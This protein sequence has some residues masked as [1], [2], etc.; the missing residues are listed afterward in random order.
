VLWESDTV[1]EFPTVHPICRETVWRKNMRISFTRW[2]SLFW[3]MYSKKTIITN[4]SML[5]NPKVLIFKENKKA[6]GKNDLLLQIFYNTWSTTFCKSSFFWK[7]WVI[8]GNLQSVNEHF[9]SLFTFLS[10]FIYGQYFFYINFDFINQLKSELTLLLF[11][12]TFFL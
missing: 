8:E 5:I 12:N 7:N 6:E 9:V 10:S 11:D 1:D 4:I 2:L 3:L